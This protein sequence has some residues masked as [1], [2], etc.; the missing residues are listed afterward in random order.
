MESDVFFKLC[1]ELVN[2]YNLKVPTKGLTVEES[3][4]T[5]LY[6]IGKGVHNRDM[7]ERFQHSGDTISHH[8]HAVLKAVKKMAT[9]ECRPTYDQNY[10]HPYIA[11]NRKYHPFKVCHVLRNVLHFCA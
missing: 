10:V 3:V 9:F 8:F 5:F 2:K 1:G 11:N 4:A 6:T 7:Q